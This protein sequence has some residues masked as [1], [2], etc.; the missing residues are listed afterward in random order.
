MAH[1]LSGGK[2]SAKGVLLIVF[3][4]GLAIIATMPVSLLH[5]LTALFCLVPA[6]LLVV[7]AES[8]RDIAFW[9]AGGLAFSGSAV[10]SATLVGNGWVTGLA[11]ALW[12]S[13]AATMAA[14]GAAAVLVR[15][16]W[17]IFPL[18]MPYLF[19]LGLIATVWLHAMGRPLAASDLPAG[20]VGLHILVGVATYALLTLASVAALAAFLQERALKLKK[21]NRLTRQLPSVADSESLSARLLMISEAVLGAGLL[22]GVA[23]E[24]LQYGRV[25]EFDHKILLSI[26]AF[27]VI[28]A[29]LLARRF[30]GVRG[31]MAARIVLVAYLLLTLAYPGVK[32]VTSVL[33]G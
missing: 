19:I 27:L 33:L 21:P 15:Q 23:V 22:S 20:W 8:R 9:A 28:G 5:S 4:S 1:T 26:L 2:S 10:L 14:F 13:I 7:R 16:A 6:S 31:R 30:T 18:L 24:W 3:R 17:R 11:P 25:I 29:L 32:F 12:V